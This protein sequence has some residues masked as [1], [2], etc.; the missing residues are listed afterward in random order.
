METLPT[1]CSDLGHQLVLTAIQPAFLHPSP[2]NK[3][4]KWTFAIVFGS[5]VPL[6]MSFGEFSKHM[7]IPVKDIRN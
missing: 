6:N 5:L 2:A 7:H 4:G 3:P 1:I